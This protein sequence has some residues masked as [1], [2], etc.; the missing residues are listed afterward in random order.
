VE[1]TTAGLVNS[2][3]LGLPAA[4]R[5]STDVVEVASRSGGLL[6]PGSISVEG[7][8]VTVHASSITEVT[9]DLKDLTGD[10]VALEAGLDVALPGPGFVRRFAVTLPAGPSLRYVCRPETAD[11]QAAFEAVLQAPFFRSRK[12]ELTADKYQTREMARAIAIFE[13]PDY[14]SVPIVNGAEPHRLCFTHIDFSSLPL[15]QLP[16]IG[17]AKGSEIAALVFENDTA[18]FVVTSAGSRLQVRSDNPEIQAALRLDADGLGEFEPEALRAALMQL[19]ASS[20]TVTHVSDANPHLGP[21]IV[22]AELRGLPGGTY[23]VKDKDGS[24]GNQVIKIRTEQGEIAE[25]RIPELPRSVFLQHNGKPAEE[26]TP[27]EIVDFMLRSSGPLQSPL[28]ESGIPTEKIDGV[29]TEFRVVF[30]F[31]GGEPRYLMAYSKVTRDEAGDVVPNRSQGGEA[32]PLRTSLRR[33]LS[34]RIPRTSDELDADVE[35]HARRLKDEVQDFAL[36]FAVLARERSFFYGPVFAVDLCPVWNARHQGIDFHL[37]EVQAGP[38]TEGAAGNLPPDEQ[39]MV[40]EYNRRVD[41][42]Q[43]YD[44]SDMMY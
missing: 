31:E 40:D 9:A 23:F 26:A 18:G 2:A 41:A 8:T 24:R 13:Q 32:E 14:R 3:G 25:A 19:T 39:L 35:S 30:V 42:E 16:T 44:I 36:K 22:R 29:L 34:A 17:A 5:P 20:Y 28:I 1:A 27:R 10:Q 21:E 12:A 43:A 37:L 38:G 6:P 11:S 33:I 4:S 7:R 15:E